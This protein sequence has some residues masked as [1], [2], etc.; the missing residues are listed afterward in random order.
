MILDDFSIPFSTPLTMMK[1]V[2]S[3][4]TT[5]QAA[6]CQGLL[7]KDWKEAMKSSGVLSEKLL[8]TASQIY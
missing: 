2:S 3:R 7:E 1:C 8:V 5:S 6:G 4:K